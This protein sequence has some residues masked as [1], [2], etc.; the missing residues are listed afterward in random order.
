MR[1]ILTALIFVLLAGVAFGETLQIAKT[2]GIGDYLADAKGMTLYVFTKDSP[3]QS[4][5]SGPCVEKWPLLMAEMIEA[6]PGTKSEDFG[7]ITRTDGQKQT[8]YKGL[9]LYY[10]FKDTKP[11]DVNGQAVNGVWFVA[12][13]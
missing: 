4:A 2:E 12:K 3:G 10:F 1:A 6:P 9:P 7:L 8:T 11:G 13:P 5:C